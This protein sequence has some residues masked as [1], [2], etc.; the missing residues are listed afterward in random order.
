M[1]K[2]L[3]RL[4]FVLTASSAALGTAQAATVT[5]TPGQTAR[6]G[7]ATV[8]LLRAQDSRCPMNARCVRAGELKVSVLAVQ[9]GRTRLLRLQL[10]ASSGDSGGLRVVGASGPL[11]GQPSRA[12][13]TVTL[14]DDR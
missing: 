6:L 10:P 13:L 7:D 1:T 9:G 5:L 3:T 12:P 2:L 11:A 14:S 4:L 8:T